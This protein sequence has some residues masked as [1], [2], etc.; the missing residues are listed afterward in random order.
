M[1][2]GARQ[3]IGLGTAQFGMHYGVT[4]PTGKVPSR[5]VKQL[6]DLALS[7]GVR[8]LDTAHS[9]G[10]AE[11]LIGDLGVGGFD[12][13]TKLASR[14]DPSSVL[15][16]HYQDLLKV[17]LARLK[18]ER[19]YGVLTHDTHELDN[20]DLGNVAKSL[21]HLKETGLTTKVGVSVYH[22]HQLEIILQEFV[23]DLVQLPF[24]LFDRR[25]L[26]SGWLEKLRKSKV[27]IH[28]RSSFLQGLLVAD[29]DQIPA[30]FARWRTLFQELESWCRESGV[31]KLEASLAFALSNASIDRVIV[32]VHSLQDLIQVLASA[33]T[34]CREFPDISSKDLDL[35]DPTRWV[36]LGD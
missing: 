19:V 31:S 9:Y 22:P 11:R 13:V 14:R 16:D 15:S 35:I 5:Q 20:G 32:G 23:P 26:D 7:K 30:S 2:D 17:S 8:L 4:N 12:V 34:T 36:L 29:L 33:G 3:R 24:S 6:L 10:D 25:F 28:S 21:L 18:L 27:E 1:A